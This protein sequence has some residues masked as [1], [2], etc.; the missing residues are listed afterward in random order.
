MLSDTRRS[1]KIDQTHPY[2][3][4][5]KGEVVRFDSCQTTRMVQLHEIIGIHPNRSC[6]LI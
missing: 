4:P 6:K 3:A 1:K 5:V 2:R